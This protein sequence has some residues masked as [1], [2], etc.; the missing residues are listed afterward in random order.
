MNKGLLVFN[1]VLLVAVV[2]LFYLFL[3]NGKTDVGRS[4]TSRL[5]DTASAWQHTPVAYFDMDSVEANFILWKQTQDDMMKRE[6]AKNDSISMLR[7]GFQNFLQ[8]MQGQF[9][10]LT[11][12]QK[13]SLNTLLNQMDADLKNRA[14]ELNQNYQSY[15]MTKQQDIVT[16]IKNYCSEFNKNGK[17]SYII[18]REP[19]LFY[20]TDTAYNI[21]AELLK[22]LNEFYDKKKK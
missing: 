19:G 1:L 5:P 20:Y 12:R 9:E 3:S 16:K 6:Q 13:D 11:S 10:T 2:V 8:K 17:Y 15:Y 7:A 22:G 18:A 4:G 14:A 21:T